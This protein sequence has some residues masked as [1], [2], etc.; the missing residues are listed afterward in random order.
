[1]DR[2]TAPVKSAIAG[3][4]REPRSQNVELN[5]TVSEREKVVE[6]PW[7]AD[8]CPCVGHQGYG[9]VATVSGSSRPHLHLA[10]YEL[11]NDGLH[12]IANLLVRSP[13]VQVPTQDV[14]HSFVSGRLECTW[15]GGVT[16]A[17]PRPVPSRRHAPAATPRSPRSPRSPL[18][19]CVATATVCCSLRGGRHPAP[20]TQDSRGE[21]SPGVKRIDRRTIHDS[22]GFERTLLVA[23]PLA[24]HRSQCCLLGCSHACVVLAIQVAP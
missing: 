5:W 13:T 21:G 10:G 18:P 12:A 19:L 2:E 8:C 14:P 3:P 20:S 17:E 7:A 23:C 11:Q 4:N 22:S 16:C 1:M 24:H 6:L 9:S 15:T